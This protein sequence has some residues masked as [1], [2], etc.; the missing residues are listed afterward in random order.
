MKLK[1]ISI[2]NIASVAEAEIDF[3]KSPLQQAKVFLISGEMGTGKTTILDAICLALFDTTPRLKNANGGKADFGENRN[4]APK[5]PCNLLRRGTSEASVRLVFDDIDGKECIATW[6]VSLTRNGTFGKKTRTF[7]KDGITVE[8][9]KDVDAAVAGSVGLEFD[10]FCRTS[11]LAQGEF[12][13]F[14]KADDDG[15]ASILEKLTKTDIYS[16]VGARIASKT[17]DKRKE[18]D[19]QQSKLQGI[20]LL[21]DEQRQVLEAGIDAL[22]KEIS[23]LQN[24]YV[25]AVKDYN[26]VKKQNELK[27]MLSSLRHQK[28][29]LEKQMAVSDYRVEEQLIKDWNETTEIR[30]KI[31]EEGNLLRKIN[32]YDSQKAERHHDFESLMQGIVFAEQWMSNLEREIEE[33]NKILE[34][35]KNK[36]EIY[37]NI[38]T[39]DARLE[40][41]RNIDAERISLEVKNK[42]LDEAFP[43]LEEAIKAEQ[44]RHEDIQ[45]VV[46]AQKKEIE[47]QKAQLLA[48]DEEGLKKKDKELNEIERNING[49]R[50]ELAS[51]RVQIESRDKNYQQLN[52]TESQIEVCEK[53]IKEQE[54]DVIRKEK[55]YH[56][57]LS[58]YEDVNIRIGDA[59]RSLR[60]QIHAHSSKYCP[61]CGQ[62]LEGRTLEA[63]DYL[64]GIIDPIK[65]AA[66]A[67]NKEMNDAQASVSATSKIIESYRQAQ[68]KQK[69]E[70]AANNANVNR[71]INK[72][73]AYLVAL[74]LR[75]DEGASNIKEVEDGLDVL[76]GESERKRN[77]L[78]NKQEELSKLK[79]A[80]QE[81]TE[82]LNSIEK[83]LGECQSNMVKAASYRDDNRSKKQANLEQIERLN[84]ER[85][86]CM[87]DADTFLNEE[88]RWQEEWQKDAAGFINDLKKQA[89]EYQDR[90]E[91][92]QKKTNKKEKADS[93]IANILRNKE[94]ILQQYPE[95]QNDIQYEPLEKKEL[96][97]KFNELAT[98]ITALSAQQKDA[99]QQL[100]IVQD[101]INRYLNSSLSIDRTRLESLMRIGKQE[102][103]RLMAV[104]KTVAEKHIE[105]EGLIKNKEEELATHNGEEHRKECEEQSESDLKEISE[106]IKFDVDEKNRL[107]GQET[108]ELTTDDNNRKRFASEKLKEEQIK[109]ELDKL[110]ILQRMFGTNNGDAFKKIAQGYLLGNLLN[111][112]NYH[113]KNLDDKYTLEC[114]QDTLTICLHDKSNKNIKSPVDTL[115][116]GE[117]FLVSLALALALASLNNQSLNIDTLFI[118]EGFGTI[119]EKEIDRVLD[120]LENLQQQQGKRVGIISHINYLSQRIPIQIH[121]ERKGEDCSSLTVVSR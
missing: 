121:A 66:D 91:T 33:I 23:Q 65:K 110:D 74:G 116:G 56:E 96:E 98:Q 30:P 7:T 53:Q 43:Q 94:S 105:I 100:T 13:K 25:L 28:E 113:L 20:V 62:S 17:T 55:I 70:L 34:R 89:K 108:Q 41:A 102:M 35:E 81:A 71:I 27:N 32:D 8:K 59:A 47:E 54:A 114:V 46:D 60:A 92:L 26:Y 119:G 83:Q 19:N 120:L 24:N 103:D 48:L 88:S 107:L 16:K 6:G 11:M 50:Q 97:I 85:K 14:L 31:A 15:K 79:N 5:D 117:S 104:H 38:Q 42:E 44:K 58:E 52:D 109:N 4:L 21:T 73:H 64:I 51:L 49:G 68:Q 99:Q 2:K 22:K 106:A 18:Y 39:I 29:E 118:D 67:A 75:L 112:A 84:E 3:T 76:A 45:K 1:K 90:V 78:T 77:E 82:R 72:A 111:T 69:D 12:T 86:T 93:I 36:K 101:A 9:I 115:S 57:R 87:A 95:W 10:Q 61:V 80:I 37:N 40:R 63:E